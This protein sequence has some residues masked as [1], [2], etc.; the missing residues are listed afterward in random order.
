MAAALARRRACALLAQPYLVQPRLR[1]RTRA[2]RFE[3]TSRRARSSRLVAVA[4]RRCSPN[5]RQSSL[6]FCLQTPRSPW[7]Q[8]DSYRPLSGQRRRAR[9]SVARAAPG[10]G[11]AAP[12]QQLPRAKPWRKRARSCSRLSVPA[13]S[14]AGRVTASCNLT[15]RR[16]STDAHDQPHC[17][18]VRA[19]A[20]PSWCSASGR[21]AGLSGAPAM[22]RARKNRALRRDR[23]RYALLAT[24][25]AASRT[26]MAVRQ[27]SVCAPIGESPESTCTWRIEGWLPY[28]SRVAKPS[29]SSTS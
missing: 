2:R 4:A 22:A 12:C 1:D 20:P 5:A 19:P 14:V 28:S 13:R 9:Q 18:P 17:A 11:H 21:H 29:T 25:A 27:Y 26:T 16:Q 24:S 23:R 3:A 7:S 8:T 15:A 6:P 10:R